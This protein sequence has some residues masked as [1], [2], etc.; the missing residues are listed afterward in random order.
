VI[1]DSRAAR[2]DI[3]KGL[4]VDPS[5]IDVVLLG[6][7]SSDAV[8]ATAEAELRGRLDLDDARVVLCVAQK[9]P[10]KNLA[11]LIRAVAA[12]EEL[13]PRLVLPGAPTPHEQEL[14][15]LTDDLGV[16][17]RVRFCDWISEPDLEGLYGLASCFVL[18]S[19]MEGFGLPVLEAMCRGVPVAC[20][21]R[22]SLPEVVGDAALL[23]DPAEQDQVT[24]CVRRL[25][26]DGDLAAQLRRRGRV[27]CAEL[28]W[29]RTAAGTLATY[30]RAIEQ[31]R[32]VRRR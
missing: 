32:G 19:L 10:Y 13:G 16:A 24:T 31:R 25:L 23:F 8:E 28:S 20:S 11:A 9:R 4:Q 21:D 6:V 27:R 2:D 18:P 26:T 3:V 14:R 5:R 17:D 29:R 22:S 30:R 12:L 1:A 15:E 7:R